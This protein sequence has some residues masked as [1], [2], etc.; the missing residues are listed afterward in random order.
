MNRA[1]SEYARLLKL[2]AHPVRLEIVHLLRHQPLFVQ[3]VQAMVGRPQAFVS[4][5]L[6]LLRA[7]GIV[8]TERIGRKVA[9][10]VADKRFLRAHDLLRSALGFREDDDARTHRIFVDPVCGMR[11]EPRTATFRHVY[12]KEPY[13]FCASGCLHRFQKRPHHFLLKT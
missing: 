5:Q 9:Y 11:L 2:L 13:Y 4:Q 8:G 12:R 7:A 6:R 10:T 1:L 3:D